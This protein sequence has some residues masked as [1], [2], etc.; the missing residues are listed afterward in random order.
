MSD[1]RLVLISD[2]H[3][4]RSHPLFHYNWDVTIGWIKAEQPDLV[5]SLGDVSL[6][7]AH[8]QDD[9]VYAR[10]QYDRLT[11][12]WL[13][14]PGNHD[15]GN[16]IPDLRGECTIDGGR[17][18]RF[19]RGFGPDHWY[20]EIG[21]WS[22]IG[23][24][25][26]LLGSGLEDEAEQWAFLK[27]ALADA[28]PRPTALFLHKPLYLTDPKATN[29]NQG[30]VFPAPRAALEAVLAAH[31]PR[32]I[33]SGHNHEIWRHQIDGRDHLWCPATS[34]ISA[35]DV[36]YRGGGDKQTGFYDLRFS[37]DGYDVV[38]VRPDS[39][40]TIDIGSWLKAGIGHYAQFCQSPFPRAE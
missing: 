35:T 14:V 24:N 34:F 33:V 23:I 12:P 3:L 17:L 37:G 11:V 21:D 15:V 32:M 30:S 36:P 13:A 10:C 29:L 39:F 1:F 5:I 19:R 18:T 31:P 4:S 9:L 25:S 27:E 26:L 7:G 16:N 38:L 8:A 20:R 40:I 6:N 28:A 22:F 2:T